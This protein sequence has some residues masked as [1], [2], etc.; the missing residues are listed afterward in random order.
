MDSVAEERD[1][2]KVFE[3][4][5]DRSTS[6]WRPTQPAPSRPSEHNLP[7]MSKDIVK[8]PSAVVGDVLE[9]VCLA[10]EEEEGA[11]STRSPVSQ[12]AIQPRISAA[13]TVV[14]NGGV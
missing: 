4:K 9:N 14:A 1:V 3:R 8:T 11:F 2:R 10:E 6:V 13:P 5:L 7:K 12:S